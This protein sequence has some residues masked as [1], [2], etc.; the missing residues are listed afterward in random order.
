MEK[1][2]LMPVFDYISNDKKSPA[3]L[4]SIFLIGRHW[5]QEIEWSVLSL[6]QRYFGTR[7][8]AISHENLYQLTIIG[9]CLIFLESTLFSIK[10]STKLFL[11]PVPVLETTRRIL[12][13]ECNADKFNI[14]EP[15]CTTGTL[16]VRINLTQ[17]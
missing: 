1:P 5:H 14:R 6:Q 13:Y 12:I 16:L 17:F 11:L 4:K 15:A 9:S 10:H 7:K 8:P 2:C 3:W